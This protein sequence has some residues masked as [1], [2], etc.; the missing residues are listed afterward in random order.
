MK[1]R[2]KGEEGEGEE[3]VGEVETLERKGRREKGTFARFKRGGRRQGDGSGG[4][5]RSLP[6]VHPLMYV[7]V[8]SV[9]MFLYIYAC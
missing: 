2:D 4:G 7:E 1:V 6:T 3:E 8:C 9:C 5:G